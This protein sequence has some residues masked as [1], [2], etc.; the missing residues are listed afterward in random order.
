MASDL[1]AISQAAPISIFQ[2]SVP[3]TL[4]IFYRG[5]FS[6]VDGSAQFVASFNF[7]NKMMKLETAAL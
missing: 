1:P 2:A 6:H 3:K 5:D 4:P 7:K